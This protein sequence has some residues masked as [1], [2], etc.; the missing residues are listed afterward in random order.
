MNSDIV[1][2]LRALAQVWRAYDMGGVFETAAN[3]IERLRADA[4]SANAASV[5]RQRGIDKE[6]ERLRGIARASGRLR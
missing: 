1:S 2:L 4:V 6:L 3:E 5:E